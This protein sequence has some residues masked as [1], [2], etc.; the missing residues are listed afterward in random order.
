MSG[1]LFCNSGSQKITQKRNLFGFCS[2]F[3]VRA[4]AAKFMF[5]IYDSA[6]F[7]G[8]EG[9]NPIFL[10]IN[11]FF[12]SLLSVFMGIHFCRAEGPGPCH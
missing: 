5:L 11:V 9:N 2:W 6:R 1:I 12:V 3:L 10:L 7:M 4:G 8:S